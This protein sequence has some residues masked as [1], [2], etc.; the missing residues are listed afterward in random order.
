MSQD[1]DPLCREQKFDGSITRQTLTG[2]RYVPLSEFRVF[3]DTCD[4]SLH[5]GI[6]MA[7][8][9]IPQRSKDSLCVR[10]VRLWEPL[11]SLK[12]FFGGNQ[13]ILTVVHVYLL[14]RQSI[15]FC[16]AVPL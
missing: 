15:F 10:S 6:R 2:V 12:N 9:H 14:L 7:F 8:I 1:P 16:W 4:M 11:L 3:P 13:A 5:K